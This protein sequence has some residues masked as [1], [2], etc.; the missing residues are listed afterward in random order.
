MAEGD[1]ALQDGEEEPH[2]RTVTPVPLGSEGFERRRH[3][4]YRLQ[5]PATVVFG[6]KRYS[7]Q[8]ED[9]AAAGVFARMDDPP[10]LRQLVSIGVELP[11]GTTFQTA[12]VVAWRIG[13]EQAIDRVPGAGLHFDPLDDQALA[14]WE[15][16]IGDVRVAAQQVAPPPI[17]PGTPEPIRRRHPRYPASFEVRPAD[18]GSLMSFFTRDVSQ[19]GMFLAT[20][21]GHRHRDRARPRSRA[22]RQR[23]RCLR[24]RGVVRHRVPA[25]GLGLEFTHLT[26]SRRQSL[27]QFIVNG[28]PHLEPDP[29]RSLTAGPRTRRPA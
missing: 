12:A 15:S 11:D 26:P 24:C 4:R 16:F 2:S 23:R 28:L 1:Q 29:D 19:G 10:A 25:E 9:V 20:Y 6:T 22:P 13:P 14:A 3:T 27:W 8:T 21:P 7:L 5:L 17:P 18:S